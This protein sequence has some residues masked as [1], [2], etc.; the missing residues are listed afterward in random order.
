MAGAID[1]DVDEIRVAQLSELA[2]I[3]LRDVAP[4]DVHRAKR[5]RPA[6]GRSDAAVTE[7]LEA[8][9]IVALN[10]RAKKMGDRVVAKIRREVADAQRAIFDP[11]VAKNEVTFIAQRRGVTLAPRYVLLENRARI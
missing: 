5:L 2:V 10:D 9:A 6:I 1:R 7:N 3:H 11:A 8:A 4:H